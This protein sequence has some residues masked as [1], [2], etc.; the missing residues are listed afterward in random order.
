[1]WV[2][3][4]Y[5]NPPHLFFSFFPYA[6]SLAALQ[7]FHSNK[8][9]RSSRGAWIFTSGLVIHINSII[10]MFVPVYIFFQPGSPSFYGVLL[11]GLI[12]CSFFTTF[13][14]IFV[15]LIQINL[16]LIKKKKRWFKYLIYCHVLNPTLLIGIIA[17]SSNFLNFHFQ[18]FPFYFSVS[19]GFIYSILTRSA[20]TNCLVSD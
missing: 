9:P 19:F 20:L 13:I 10:A 15:G 6:L 2:L 11:Q 18:D 12:L 3:T 4:L 7:T 17:W 8:L 16:D 14:T 5:P 1:M